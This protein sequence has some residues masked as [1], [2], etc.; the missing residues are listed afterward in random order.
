MRWRFATP[1]S[2]RDRYRIA[3]CLNRK[4]KQVLRFLTP[5]LCLDKPTTC[6]LK[7]EK[8][9]LEAYTKRRECGWRLVLVDVLT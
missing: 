1:P 9:I 5:I 7:L 2:E 8:A 4:E 3:D 6:M